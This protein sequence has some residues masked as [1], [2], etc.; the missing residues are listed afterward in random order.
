MGEMISPLIL[1]VNKAPYPGILELSDNDG[2]TTSTVTGTAFAIETDSEQTA[3][4]NS[5]GERVKALRKSFG[6]SQPTLAARIGIS[7]PAIS[8][9]EK[10]KTKTL[11][12][13]VLAGL[14]EH[15]NTTP[16]LILGRYDSSQQLEDAMLEA[17]LIKICR[18]L[19]PEGRKALQSV[20]RGLRTEYSKRST[21]TPRG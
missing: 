3:A 13:H 1:I 10:N 9:I 2:M 19:T 5:M 20:A 7:Q 16:E 12:G 18:D 8:Q 17:E 15:L 21:G 11:R 14:C 6:L 4:D